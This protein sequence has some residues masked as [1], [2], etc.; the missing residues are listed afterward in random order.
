MKK[1]IQLSIV[2]IAMLGLVGCGAKKA[3]ISSKTS[4]VM[5]STDT[6]STD[7]SDEDLASMIK[8]KSVDYTDLV[9][10]TDTYKE[11]RISLNGT[12]VQTID[13]DDDTQGL[14]MAIDDDE[15]Q[16]M[17]VEYNPSSLSGTRMVE[18]DT[19]TVKGYGAGTFTYTTEDG[20][21]EIP[22]LACNEV[23]R[24]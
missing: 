7:E 4:Y 15:S 17:M 16:P 19:I 2:G 24:D 5:K 22:A 13:G 20:E 3:S 18:D 6:D 23:V 21:T 10:D 14:L 8:Y 1:W 11:K 9:D 12:V